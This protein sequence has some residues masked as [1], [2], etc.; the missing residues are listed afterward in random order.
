MLRKARKEYACQHCG[1]IIKTGEQ[2]HYN[3]G[4]QPRYKEIHPL[5]YCYLNEQ[6]G[7]EYWKDYMCLECE[8]ERCS[9]DLQWE[10]DIKKVLCILCGFEPPPYEEIIKKGDEKWESNEI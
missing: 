10:P 6:I 7:I 5:D 9:H 8:H 2:Y 1:R 3:E 4:R